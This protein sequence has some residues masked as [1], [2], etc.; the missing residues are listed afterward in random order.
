M[1][2]DQVLALLRQ[3]EKPISGEEM[4]RELGVS[5][6]AVWK[7]MRGLRGEGYVISAAP[8]RGYH[9]ESSPDLLSA[10]ELAGGLEGCTLGR[11]LVCLST[12]DSTNTEVK[13]RAVA[14]APEGLVILSDEQTGGRGRWSRTFVSPAGKGIYCSVLLRPRV[15]V[16]EACRF[17]PWVG[18]AV[19]D[20][21]EAVCGVRPGIK[22]TND[23]VLGNKKLGGI[24]CE[25]AVEESGQA[26]YVV[27]GVGLNVT[28]TEAD[29]GPE[30]APIATSLAQQLD[31]VP[32]RAELTCA[33]LRALDRWYARFPQDRAAC[34]EQYR[35]DCVTLG[36][37]VCIQR[38]GE[39]IR[40]VAEDVNENFELVIRRPGADHAE[41]VGGGEVSV[42]GLF[43][44]LD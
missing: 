25:L 26:D 29:F 38:S 8:N 14:G 17:T 35:R 22:W 5:R 44:Y 34:L 4:S 15:D 3:G 30:V 42:R 20:A 41:T 43:G 31:H 32:R 11:E 24:L 40:A 21:I 1:L 2:R 16:E 33:L 12:I 36:R 39:T 18:V 6:A 27:I 13:R 10:G 37:E 9:L 7:V 19:C 28:Q 23:I